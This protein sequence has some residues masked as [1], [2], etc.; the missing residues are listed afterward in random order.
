M[1]GL[2]SN[3]LNLYM[4]V[5]IVVTHVS[6]VTNTCWNILFPT[7]DFFLK[8]RKCPAKGIMNNFRLLFN[9]GCV[10]IG[11]APEIRTPH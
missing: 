1:N 2:C 11:L 5:R 8:C 3:G 10:N 7:C 4:L 6:A 9:P